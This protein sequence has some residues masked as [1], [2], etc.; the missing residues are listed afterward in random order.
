MIGASMTESVPPRKPTR[1]ESK[2]FGPLTVTPDG[3]VR[4]GRG[5]TIVPGDIDWNFSRSGG[6]GGQHANKTS[7]KAELRL[8]L[9]CIVG[10]DPAALDRLRLIGARHV[11]GEGAEEALLITDSQTRSQADNRDACVGRLS[12]LVSSAAIRPKIRRETKRT[13]GSVV[14]RL[15]GKKR[16]A[17][18]KQGR[19]SPGDEH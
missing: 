15:E 4:L 10:L 13:W 16:D 9:S 7:T 3:R 14:R 11:V 18:K 8:R 2:R 17:D 19:Q 6:P 5:C 12:A 1:V